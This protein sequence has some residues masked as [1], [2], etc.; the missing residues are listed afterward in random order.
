MI[1]NGPQPN[2]SFIG[3]K[4]PSASSFIGIIDAIVDAS[5]DKK[6][7]Y[8]S[9]SSTVTLPGPVDDSALIFPI[10]SAKNDPVLGSV[11]RLRLPITSSTV[12]ARPFENLAVGRSLKI[13]VVGDG[14]SQDSAIAGIGPIFTSRAVNPS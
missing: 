11:R 9:S 12:S 4:E 5:D 14:F 7:A 13:Y 6:G 3:S 2:I 10:S 1:L 8:G